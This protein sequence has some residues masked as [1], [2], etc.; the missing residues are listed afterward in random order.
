MTLSLSLCSCACPRDA[1]KSGKRLLKE[2]NGAAAMV[3]FEKALM[4]CKQL[5]DKVGSVS[6]ALGGWRVTS[7]S[8]RNVVK[9]CQCIVLM[10]ICG[11]V[12]VR[13]LCLQ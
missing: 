13:T 1:L 11:S 3:R 4:L 9:M 6:L 8:T 5:G 12:L 10:A 7:R 2:K